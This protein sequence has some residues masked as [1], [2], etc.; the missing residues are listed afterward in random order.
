MRSVNGILALLVMG[1]VALLWHFHAEFDRAEGL[2]RELTAK[3][4]LL[5][6]EN[7]LLSLALDSAS[8]VRE[9]A[10]AEVAL[11]QNEISRL[12][13]D[14]KSRE[15]RNAVESRTKKQALYQGETVYPE[16]Q[17]GQGEKPIISHKVNALYPP[18][19][20]SS[21]P[22]GRVDVSFIVDKSGNV[23]DLRVE[24]A[25]KEE[26]KESVVAAISAWK[27]KAATKNGLPINSRITTSWVFNTGKPEDSRWF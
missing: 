1:A 5:R 7:R 19:L 26:F 3:L 22:N 6:N 2:H 18:S 4:T 24:F 11:L 27:Y 8:R 17:L 13:E 14:A 15:E 23:V 16:S 10:D 25:S 12:R 21:M 9:R 20:R